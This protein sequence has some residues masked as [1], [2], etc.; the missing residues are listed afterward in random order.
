MSAPSPPLLRTSIV[1]RTLCTITWAM[2][3]LSRE[4]IG[5]LS[6]TKTIDEN[7]TT[8]TTTI[9]ASLG[10][11]ECWRPFRKS[12]RRAYSAL[13]RHHH[14]HG[15]DDNLKKRKTPIL[16]MRMDDVDGCSTIGALA[17]DIERSILEGAWMDVEVRRRIFNSARV[18]MT[19]RD[20]HDYELDFAI[21]GR[22]V[23]LNGDRHDVSVK[24]PWSFVVT[25]P[26]RY[27]GIVV[28]D[29]D[30]DSSHHLEY[31]LFRWYYVLC[32][33]RYPS[34]LSREQLL[35]VVPKALSLCATARLDNVRRRASY[36]KDHKHD[37]L[38]TT[39]ISHPTRSSLTHANH[40]AVQNQHNQQPD[41]ATSSDSSGDYFSFSLHDAQVSLPS[42][43]LS[44]SAPSPSHSPSPSPSSYHTAP[45]EAV[46]TTS[47]LHENMCIVLNLDTVIRDL[48]EA[49]SST[50]HRTIV[51]L[52]DP[53]MYALDTYTV[54]WESRLANITAGHPPPLDEAGSA[55]SVS[56]KMKSD[57]C[58]VCLKCFD[59]HSKRITGCGHVICAPCILRWVDAI[60]PIHPTCPLCRQNLGVVAKKSRLW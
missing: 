23:W 32:V 42:G 3:L 43:V 54:P 15:D 26:R 52:S 9:K 34:M 53:D 19:F 30:D 1:V 48:T 29:D 10:Q 46:M 36:D 24:Y 49:L 7:T 47:T 20:R 44:P 35:Q 37:D 45:E 40:A 25:R 51:R 41:S 28:G 21:E 6:T 17:A 50:P 12:R 60:A 57:E 33:L 55:L 18:Y 59:M 56:A 11:D 13:P 2:L 27:V 58:P 8:N 31:K 22:I 39:T 14:V 16:C 4:F 38:T 5:D